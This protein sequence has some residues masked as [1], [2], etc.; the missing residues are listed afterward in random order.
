MDFPNSE[1]LQKSSAKIDGIKKKL[2]PGVWYNPYVE[3]DKK[4]SWISILFQTSSWEPNKKP[5][6]MGLFALSLPVYPI[7][8]I[9]IYPV[10]SPTTP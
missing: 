10:Y 8:P 3:N 9:Y 6:S 1:I 7:Y 4:N 5:R 2:I